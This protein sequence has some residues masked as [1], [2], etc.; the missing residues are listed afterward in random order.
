MQ[1]KLAWPDEFSLDLVVPVLSGMPPLK[2]KSFFRALRVEGCSTASFAKV[3][4]LFVVDFL[5]RF[6]P[7]EKDEIELT[8]ETLQNDLQEIGEKLRSE[9]AGS[10]QKVAVPVL[11]V[12]D[13][14]YVGLSGRSDFIDLKTGEQVRKPTRPM[15][16]AVTYNLAAVASHYVHR[17]N[18][19]RL[20][21]AENAG[22]HPSPAS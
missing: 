16:E 14:S 5:Y 15:T 2:R 11:T 13:R 6:A 22:E 19:G 1:D 20:G 12:L 18:S 17:Y 9:F 8:A 21:G 10:S 4:F 7:L 3:F